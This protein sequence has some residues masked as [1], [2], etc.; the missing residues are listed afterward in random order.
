MPGISLNKLNDS[1]SGLTKRINFDTI[2]TA[3]SSAISE[4]QA[5]LTTK[6]GSA[7]GT[8]VG[9][10]QSLT[11]EVDIADLEAG[12]TN[13]VG[14]G[15][16]LLT[17]NPS[18]VN[19]KS[20][21][22]SG[23]LSDLQNLTG[24]T[25]DVNPGLNVVA[26]TLPTPEAA[27]ATVQNISGKNL[28]ELSGVMESLAPVGTQALAASS[29]LKQ[30]SNSTGFGIAT[31]FGGTVSK[32]L[33]SLNTYLTQG[34]GQPLKDLVE[35][36]NSPLRTVVTSVTQDS[37]KL[38]PNSV[39]LQVNGLVDQGKFLEASKIL[40]PYSNLTASEIETTLSNVSTKLG[41]NIDPISAEL[42]SVLPPSTAPV[43]TIGA[44][45]KSWKGASTA[46]RKPGAS[47]TGYSFT[48][49]SRVEE[50]EAEIR[51]STREITEVVIHW[52]EHFSNQNVGA[53]EI[54][55]SHPNG[56]GYHYIIRKDGT[57]Q[58][59]RPVNIEGEHAPAKTHDKYS[60]GI[61]IVGGFTCPSGTPNPQYYLSS[62][63]INTSQWDTLENFLRV[64]Y[65]VF[66]GG[67][68]LGH[69]Q[70]TDND[71]KDPGFDVDD[72]IK[73]HFNKTNAVA[74]NNNFPSYSRT[75]LIKLR[76]SS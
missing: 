53:E 25:S 26:A 76:V 13:V 55:K 47:G 68:V 37:G 23:N 73:K 12:N 2:Q 36:V 56:L 57:L 27:A 15:M 42:Q 62:S 1:L 30:L 44:N 10:F 38:V 60:I 50:I 46:I 67:Q 65:R 22:S 51:S 75:E 3:A 48:I 7:V 35:V 20:T 17:D 61:A 8:N 6:L 41:D 66:P 70:C 21:I 18:G 5:T 71:D 45:D 24:L 58:R 33:G 4:V 32:T 63:S 31:S 52:T 40:V 69:Y 29:V 43:T 49:V 9:G 39:R 59:G 28:S 72:Y 34:F 11:Q 74:Y 16:S 54:H 14:K 64:F 19:L